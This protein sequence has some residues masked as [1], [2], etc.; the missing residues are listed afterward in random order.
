MQ[1]LAKVI[2]T[3]VMP[4]FCCKAPEI[5]RP[6]MSPMLFQGRSNV[7]KV[8]FNLNAIPSSCGSV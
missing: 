1:T 5:T 4:Q 2:N 3:F 6:P 7:D 8:L